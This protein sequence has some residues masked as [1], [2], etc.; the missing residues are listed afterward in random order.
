MNRSIMFPLFAIGILVVSV[1]FGLL[2]IGIVRNMDGI[3]TKSISK[4]S[5]IFLLGV[6][7]FLRTTNKPIFI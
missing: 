7:V 2:F 1:A 6:S 4:W 5:S 3:T